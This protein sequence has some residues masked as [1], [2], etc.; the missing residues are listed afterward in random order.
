VEHVAVGEL[1]EALSGGR[2]RAPDVRGDLGGGQR[3]GGIVA[4]FE[5]APDLLQYTVRGRSRP[6]HE[7]E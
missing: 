4:A 2:R 6:V 1:R 7:L 5:A 3:R